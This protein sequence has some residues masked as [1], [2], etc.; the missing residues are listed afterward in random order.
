MCDAFM[1][2]HFSGKVYEAYCELPMAVM[3][4][5]LWRYCILYTYGGIY[6]D[7]DAMCN[8]NPDIFTNSKT[9][10]VC[11]PENEGDFLCQW[12]FAAPKNSPFLKSIIDLSVERIL[13]QL[14]FK[15]E[16]LIH[17]LTGPAC[18][19]DGV[20]KF[21]QEN[22]QP[23]FDNKIQY[24]IYRNSLM[25]IFNTKNFHKNLIHHQFAGSAP[26]G[27]KVERNRKL[28]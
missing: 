14:H 21:L 13:N 28:M 26:D 25:C 18:F 16:H 2:E 22:Q 10:L 3:K 11:A 4:A 27:W 8:M 23:T 19:T 7:T 6:S 24:E 5:D 17:Y 12:C 9:L 15:G 1:K 20:E